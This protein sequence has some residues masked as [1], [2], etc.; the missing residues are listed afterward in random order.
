MGDPI[1]KIEL[2]DG[3]TRYRFVIDIGRDPATGKRRQLTKTYDTKKAA[4]AEYAKV[5]RQTD[6]GTFVGPDKTTVSAWLDT[7]LKSTTVG[8]E[9]ATAANYADALLPVRERLGEKRLQEVTE[10]DADELVSWMLTSGRK[11]G[12]K[13]GSGLSVRSVQPTLGRFRSS[14]NVASRRGLVVRN[15]AWYTQIP[16]EARRKAAAAAGALE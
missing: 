2:K 1:E 6:E 8:V 4:R 16:R 7:W 3:T 14:R 10:E 15:I 11:R 9:K 13:V 5:K 12:G